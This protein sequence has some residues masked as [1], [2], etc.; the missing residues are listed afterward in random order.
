[1]QTLTRIASA[2]APLAL[3]AGCATASHPTPDA[4]Y[5]N[6]A[7]GDVQW[8]D[9][10]SGVGMALGGAIAG[11]AQGADY[12]RCKTDWETKGYVRLDSTAKLSAEDQQ[13]YEDALAR[14]NK[15]R[16]DSIRKN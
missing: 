4:I 16:A 15:A 8:C 6:A 14:M 13:R 3:L 2:V 5:R 9:K 7:T 1:M 10:P 12:A 11:A